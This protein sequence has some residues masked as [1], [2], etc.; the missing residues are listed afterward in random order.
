MKTDSNKYPEWT[1]VHEIEINNIEEAKKIEYKYL[2]QSNGRLTTRWETFKANR[3]LDLSAYFGGHHQKWTMKVQVI[4]GIFDKLSQ[5]KI[6]TMCD[7][8][9]GQVL[10]P[11]EL[12]EIALTQNTY[13]QTQRDAQ[14]GSLINS[15]A[16]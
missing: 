6:I 10:N 16:H 11:L 8:K 14:F 1:T 4:D 2:I 15:S 12:G 3:T 7:H 9:H 13:D 5:A